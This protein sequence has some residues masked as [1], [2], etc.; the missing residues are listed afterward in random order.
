MAEVVPLPYSRGRS[1]RYSNRLLSLF[2]G[3]FINSFPVP[4]LSFSSFSYN[5][6]PRSGCS[7]LHGVKLNLKK[8]NVECPE[9]LYLQY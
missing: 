5:F 3:L 4:F 9:I 7:A 6:M 8:S 2:F 1:T